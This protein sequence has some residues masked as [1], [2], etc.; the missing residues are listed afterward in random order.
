MSEETAKKKRLAFLLNADLHRAFKSICAVN[1]REMA[2]VLIE[3]VS[4]YVDTERAAAQQTLTYKP[5]RTDADAD[6]RLI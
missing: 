6:R 2:E 1:G 3:L 5:F 4:L